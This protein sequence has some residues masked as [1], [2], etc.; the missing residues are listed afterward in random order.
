[1]RAVNSNPAQASNWTNSA[2]IR[3]VTG[4]LLNVTSTRS[5]GSITL[6]WSPSPWTTGYQIHCAEADMTPPYSASVYTLCATLTGQ[7]DTATSHSV[8]I[9]H[10]TNSTYTIDNTK[11]YNIKIISANQWGQ[12]EM[13]APLVFPVSVGAAEVA[14]TTAKLKVA[15]HTGGWWYKGGKLSGTPGTCTSLLSGLEADTPYE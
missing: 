3:P 14:Q 13:L 5:N 15:N 2:N 7:V 10:S 1:M 6:S 4:K 9:P 11:T 12:G 8:T